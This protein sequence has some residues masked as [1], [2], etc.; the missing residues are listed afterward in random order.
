MAYMHASG[1]NLHVGQSITI[2]PLSLPEPVAVRMPPGLQTVFGFTQPTQYWTSAN[3]SADFPWSGED[4]AAMSAAG[5]GQPVDG[6]VAI[7]VRALSSLL[8]LT[9]PVV[10]PGITT[11]VT[12]ANVAVILLHD[13]Y[14]GAPA[15]PRRAAGPELGGRHRR[16]RRPHAPPRRRR[17]PGAHVGSRRGRSTPSSSGTFGHPTR[18]PWS[19]TAPRVPSTRSHPTGHSTW[20]S[21]TLAPTSSTTT[22]RSAC[23]R[24]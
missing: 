11:P 9:G 14:T 8:A 19:A 15:A 6:V 12:A 17:R 1:G 23:I 3:A 16:G 20:P 18:P 7:D 2:D 22:C 24:T 13:D 4:L 21:R 10:V 5:F